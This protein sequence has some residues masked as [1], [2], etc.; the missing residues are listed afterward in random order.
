VQ[1]LAGET[2]FF[3]VTV[4]LLRECPFRDLAAGPAI[5]STSRLS[6]VF[7]TSSQAADSCPLLLFVT[8]S[9]SRVS[10]SPVQ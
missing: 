9:R 6:S 7:I 10:S 4:C 8:G 5:A 1:K 2:L 3:S